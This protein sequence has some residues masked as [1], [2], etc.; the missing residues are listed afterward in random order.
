MSTPFVV[1]G[2]EVVGTEVVGFAA[3]VAASVAVL[4]TVF[5]ASVAV[6]RVGMS[7]V[8][9]SLPLKPGSELAAAIP[10]NMRIALMMIAAFVMSSHSFRVG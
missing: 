2:T 10:A 5:V 4:P 3:V 6:P 8:G 1:V 9:E 7:T